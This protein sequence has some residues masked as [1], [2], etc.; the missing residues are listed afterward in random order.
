MKTKVILSTCASLLFCLPVLG[1]D[2]PQFRGPANDGSSAEKILTAWPQEGPK[3]VW[4][5]PVGE[6]FGAISVSGDKAFCF[7][8]RDEKEVAVAMDRQTGKELWAVPLGESIKDRQGGDGPRTTPAVDG[9]KVYVL[10]TWLNLVCLNAADGKTVWS[11]DIEKEF[12]GVVP[13][14]GNAASPIIEGDLLFVCGGGRGQSIIAFDKTTGNVAWKK[15]DDEITHASPTPATIHGVRQIIFRTGSGLVAVAPKTGDVLWRY[16]IPHRV[17]SA[18]SPVVGGDIVYTSSAYGI[19]AGA[20]KVTKTDAGFSA[21]E[22]WR[23]AGLQNHWTT[24]VY[25]DGYLY[26]LY[27]Q[28]ST[29]RCIEMATGKEV[30]SKSGFGWGGATILV[31]GNVLVQDER[32]ELVLVKATPEKYT[33]LTRAHPL[34]GKCWTM[35]VI[36]DG[37]IYARSTQEA[38][39]LDVAGQKVARRLD[40]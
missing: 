4:K 29:L 31:E 40:R 32:G 2:W 10:G 28:P 24:P 21:A 26:G 38:V 5:V 30:W 17:S 3:E 11:H 15:H 23:D 25:H 20:C 39:C 7:M 19:G 36:S 1:A 18:A 12:G 13:K 8:Q 27:K 33:E 37:R 9:D 34:G 35:P 16:A 22:V 6:A 14:W